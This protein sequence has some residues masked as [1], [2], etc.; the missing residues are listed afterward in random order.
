MNTTKARLLI[1]SAMVVG[2]LAL[3]GCAES[4]E[5][6]AEEG[7]MTGYIASERDAQLEIDEQQE[8]WSML[9]V[10][11]VKV[12]E[13]AWIVVHLDDDG[14]PG[15]RVGLQPVDEGE[16]EDVSVQLENVTTEN[17]IVAVHADRGEEG[18]FEFDG[19]DMAGSPD[20]PFFVNGMELAIVV[21]V[22]AAQ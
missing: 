6:G 14:M 12:P 16:S 8:S 21:P 7:G 11:R 5:S 18:E 22:P 20:K 3:A 19:D 9:T 10:D 2:L 4:T 1:S 15:E 17:V 13:N